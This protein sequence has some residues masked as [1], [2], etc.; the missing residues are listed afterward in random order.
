[1]NYSSPFYPDD[2]EVVTTNGKMKISKLYYKMNPKRDPYNKILDIQNIFLTKCISNSLNKNEN[3]NLKIKKEKNLKEIKDIND[4]YNNINKEL[5]Y[6]N[7]DE[8]KYQIAL[9]QEKV[10][11]FNDYSTIFQTS[12]K[13]NKTDYK[14][15]NISCSESKFNNS[16]NNSKVLS[17]IKNNNL[18]IDH[19]KS[20]FN[21]PKILAHSH[22]Y[23]LKLDKTYYKYPTLNKK[24][25]I[26]NHKK[27]INNISRFSFSNNSSGYFNDS[28]MS[29]LNDY[30]PFAKQNY[31]NRQFEFDLSKKITLG[32]LKQYQMKE[33]QNRNKVKPFIY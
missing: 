31:L 19:S 10:P 16:N 15:K 26:L 14:S 18:S 30:I 17:N 13:I 11:Y 2:S 7:E 9:N 28:D 22:S 5:K 12:I 1:M 8:E 6:N 20:N 21:R 25:Y 29:K 3:S 27:K 32:Q 24:L 4:Y 23:V 33:T